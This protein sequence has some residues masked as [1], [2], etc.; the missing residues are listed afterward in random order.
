MRNRC[1]LT[2][3]II[4]I[5]IMLLTTGMAFAQDYPEKAISVVYHSQAGS[6]G[7]IFLRNM[8]KAIEKVL[9]Q[10]IVVENRTGGGGSNAW[11]YVKNA[12]PDGYTLLGISSSLLA[13]PL[14]TEMNVDYTDFDPI[15]QVFFDPS[16]IFVPADSE[17]ETFED[18]I[19]D[20]KARPGQ[21]KWGAGNPGSAETMVVEKVAQLADMDINVIPFEGGSDVMVEI[22]AGRID[23]AVGEYAEIANQVEAGNIKLIC[24]LNEE[25]MDNLPEL[26]TL[27]ESGIDFV[28]E[29]IR[30][31][32]APKGTP[33]EV[34]QTWVEAIPK[35]YDDPEF[36]NYYT[37]NV[38]FPQ[39]RPTEEMKKAMDSQYN[40]FKEMSEGL[41]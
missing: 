26:P 3:F 28:F 23:A 27:K 10:P 32:V 21:Q 41:Y 39:F 20:A 35:I 13:G 16:V 14:Q 8:G 40:F 4:V 12:D 11:S 6:G 25:R 9:G 2:S 31:I 17:L 5:S 22:V 30:G 36:K 19:A 38:L 7:D 18:I 29:K 1:L 33:D 34:I 37:E 15:A 24:N